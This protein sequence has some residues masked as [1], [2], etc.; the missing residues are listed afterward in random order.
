MHA[1]GVRHG[2]F[3]GILLGNDENWVTLFYA[4][5]MLGAVTVPVNTR[6][7]SAELGFCLAAGRREG[8]VLRRPLSQHRFS[9]VPARGRAGGRSRAARRSTA[10]LGAC[11]CDRTS[12]SRQR[13]ELRTTSCALGE[14]VTDNTLDALAAQVQPSD[15]LLIQFTSGTT[16]YPKAV[17]LTH[18]NMLRDAWA[19]GLAHGHPART[20]A[21]STAGRS[22]MSPARRCRCWSR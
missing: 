7:K 11:G 21:T 6:F 2:D 20:T 17:M 10:I 5:A 16:A 4:A 22:S 12:T 9:L 3:V 19:V 1:L 18:D 13:Q 15:L 14:R 8:A